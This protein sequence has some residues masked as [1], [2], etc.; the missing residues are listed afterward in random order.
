MDSLPHFF[1]LVAVFQRFDWADW[2]FNSDLF[3][4]ADHAP[5]APTGEL[6]ADPTAG[7]STVRFRF[8]Q[9]DVLADLHYDKDS[10][11]FERYAL[12]G[13]GTAL[14]KASQINS[15]ESTDRPLVVKISWP[16]EERGNEADILKTA[17]GINDPLIRGHI[18]ELIAS[19]TFD[20]NTQKIRHEIGRDKLHPN[21]KDAVASGA[22]VQRML[23]VPAL[24]P[25]EGLTGVEFYRALFDCIHCMC[26]IRSERSAADLVMF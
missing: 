22:R 14:Y 16:E 4:L 10:V 13:R 15:G 17:A 23:L 18:P 9:P 11:V 3:P 8:S 21:D 1:L 2:G 19:H 20:Y 5:I 7:P 12:L 26:F 24:K 25:I 6:D